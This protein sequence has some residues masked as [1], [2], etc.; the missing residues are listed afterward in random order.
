[1]LNKYK[2]I[3]KYWKDKQIIFVLYLEY[4][5]FTFLSQQYVIAVILPLFIQSFMKQ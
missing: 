5:N 4:H 1:M 3:V 2:T